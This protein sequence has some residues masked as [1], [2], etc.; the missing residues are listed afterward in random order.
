MHDLVND[1]AEIASS[2]L[3][4]RFEESQGSHMSEKSRH[5]SYSMRYGDFEKLT[6]LYKL[7]QLRTLLPTCINLD[8]W[9]PL[10]KRV[11]LNILPSLRSLRVLLKMPLHLNKLKSLQVLVGVKFLLG[12]GGGSRMEDLGEVHNLYGSLSMLE[13]QNVVDR[14]EARKAKMRGKEHVDKLSIVDCNSL[15]SLPFSILFALSLNVCT[16]LVVGGVFLS[17]GLQVLTSIFIFHYFS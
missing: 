15:T 17:S 3:C 13:L 5:L 16:Y 12:G 1:L 4:I 6:P 9:Y 10:S 7:E 11:E 14:R 8:N 2:K